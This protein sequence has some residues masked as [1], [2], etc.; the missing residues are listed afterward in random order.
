MKQNIVKTRLKNNQPVLG[1]LSN[2]TDPTV[3]ELC[4]FSG[5]DFYMIDGEHSPVTTA[6]VQDIV[7]ACEGSGITPLARVRSNDP[8]LILQFLDTGVMGI[9]MPGVKTVAEVE[10]LVQAVKYPPLGNRGFG[11][12]RASDYLLGAMNQGEFVAFS[13]EQ[14]LILPQIE[15]REAIDNIDDLL[16]VEGIDGFVIGPRDLAMSMGYFDGPAHDEVRRTIAGVVEKIRKAGLVVGT[17]AA[18]GDQARA[19]IDRGVMF[20]LNSFAGLVKSAAGEFMKGRQ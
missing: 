12:A 1:V 11:P 6:Q 14:T 4:G 20:C 18:T 7:R 5:L 9:M 19:L 10:A 8:K 13:N 15:D 16:T 2:S 17:T 3:A